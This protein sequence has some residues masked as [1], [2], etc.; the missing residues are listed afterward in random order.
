MWG[1][2]EGRGV[3]GGRGCSLASSLCS[4][5]PPL[6]LSQQDF[7]IPDQHK[8]SD[9]TLM[10]MLLLGAGRPAYAIPCEILV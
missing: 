8:E 7:E 5:V 6:R 2:C 1:V 10:A 9:S 4:H 3:G